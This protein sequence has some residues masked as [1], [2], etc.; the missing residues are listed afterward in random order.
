MAGND[1]QVSEDGEYYV[2]KVPK[3]E[4]DEMRL[5]LA[6]IASI[7]DLNAFWGPHKEY[8]A[9]CADGRREPITAK[10]SWEAA[11]VGIAKCGGPCQVSRGGC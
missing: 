4:I 3:A 6:T 2:I 10:N 1:I 7:D 5:K 11:V 9:R 8:C